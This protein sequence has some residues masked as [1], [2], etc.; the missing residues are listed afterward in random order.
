M[1]PRKSGVVNSQCHPCFLRTAKVTTA[2]NKGDRLSRFK[3]TGLIIMIIYY[4]ESRMPTQRNFLVPPFAE[5][6]D[7][8]SA[9]TV[10]L[11]IFG[12]I[13]LENET[14]AGAGSGVWKLR[15]STTV[16]TLIMTTICF[17][18]FEGPLQF[19]VTRLGELYFIDCQDVS[20]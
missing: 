12:T 17:L 9:G 11:G 16:M 4:Q 7:H 15:R 10:E 13:S 5:L 18:L 3:I 19:G 14:V 2:F 1:I 6:Q 20:E 8:S